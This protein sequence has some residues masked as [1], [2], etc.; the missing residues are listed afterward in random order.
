[1]AIKQ[2]PTN[3]IILSS[4]T[5]GGHNACAAALKAELA[6]RCDAQTHVQIVDLWTD[7]APFPLN[8]LPRT[9]PFFV[10]HL[11]WLW[12]WAWRI[13]QSPRVT[14][15]LF[16]L[17]TKWI[18]RPVLNVLHAHN[19]HLIICVHPIVQFALRTMLRRTNKPRAAKPYKLPWITVVT[20]LCASHSFWFEPT[21]DLCFVDSE[22]TEKYAILNGMGADRVCSHGLP[23]H[24]TFYAPAGASEPTNL[25]ALRQTLGM[26]QVLPA[27][28]LVGGGDGI[29]AL[30]KQANL[31]ACALTDSSG[32]K[33]QLVIICGNNHVLCQKLRQQSWPVPVR[34]CGLVHNMAQ[35]MAAC[36][37]IVTKAGPSTIAEAVASSLPIALT[38]FIPGQEAANVDYVTENGLGRFCATDAELVQTVCTWL[39]DDPQ[40]REGVVEQT[41]RMSKQRATAYIVED[42]LALLARTN[43]EG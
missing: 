23:I 13:T 22:I 3:I 20:D 31:L 21:V 29:G 19:P 35:W 33:G 14:K 32:A 30:Q 17:I 24:P 12:A 28:L 36:D 15:P 37:C 34:V 16:A 38:G 4:H 26:D 18:E 11:P 43:G 27:A 41:R 8:L 2:H 42:I 1:M 9:Y 5:G 25:A 39:V 10:Q 40:T 7:Q 6:A